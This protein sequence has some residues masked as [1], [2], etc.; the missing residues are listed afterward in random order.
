MSNTTRNSGRKMT[1]LFWKEYE[2]YLKNPNRVKVK[3][4][5]LKDF[6]DSINLDL[7]MNGKKAFYHYSIKSPAQPNYLNFRN[8]IEKRI[9]KDLDIDRS[10]INEEDDLSWTIDDIAAKFTDFDLDVRK[11]DFGKYV[12]AKKI[13]TQGKIIG[14]SYTCSSHEKTDTHLI[15]KYLYH[16]DILVPAPI[17]TKEYSNK[18]SPSTLERKDIERLDGFGQTTLAMY[19]DITIT[20][21]LNNYRD[22][23]VTHLD[24]D[25]IISDGMDFINLD[26]FL[27][28]DHMKNCHYLNS[29]LIKDIYNGNYKY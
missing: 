11:R 6:E 10:E 18:K 24:K 22:C 13:H 12:N 19:K 16:Y 29:K 2:N 1:L 4:N 8:M 7:V 27:F 15:I 20:L 17:Y 3:S 21:N 28:F 26:I 14:G 23:Q 9:C 25:L 5:F